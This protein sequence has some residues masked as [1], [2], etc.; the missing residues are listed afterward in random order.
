MKP[1]EIEKPPPV[2][3]HANPHP[4]RADRRHIKPVRFRNGVLVGYKIFV[5]TAYQPP[6]RNEPYVKPVES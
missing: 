6:E 1:W 5:P 4:N 2:V 3:L